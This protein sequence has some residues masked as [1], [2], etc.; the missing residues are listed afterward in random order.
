M[1]ALTRFFFT[2]VY[3]PRSMWSV[4]NWWES[5]RAIYNLAVGAAGIFSLTFVAFS[6]VFH[7]FPVPFRVPVLGILAYAIM[8]NLCYSMGPA[9]DV[10]IHRH[11][12]SEY[13]VVGPTL[14]RYG[15]VFS[16]G[17]S[18]LPI[19]VAALAWMARLFFK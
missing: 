19:P 7:P 4:V 6:A 18:L 10:L 17:L 1:S 3:A 11:W 12:G 5:R 16:I 13:A 2:P 8:A 15:F 9:I 14:F